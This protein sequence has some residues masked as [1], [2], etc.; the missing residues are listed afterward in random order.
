MLGKAAPPA[1][2]LIVV[3]EPATPDELEAVFGMRELPAGEVTTELLMAFNEPAAQQV[4]VPGG[5][6]IMRAADLA[7]YYQACC[8]TPARCGGP[9]CWPTPTGNVRNHLPERTTGVPANRTLGLIQ[10]GDDGKS[11]LRGLGRTVSPLAVGHN[12]ARGADRVG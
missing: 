9:T 2:E 10:A 7:L 12:G 3:G 6:G 11:N 8:T 5:G 1:A 4:G